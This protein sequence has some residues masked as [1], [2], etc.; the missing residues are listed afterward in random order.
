MSGPRAAD[1]VGLAALVLL[2]LYLGF[3]DRPAPRAPG[4]AAVTPPP[5]TIPNGPRSRT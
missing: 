3:T 1:W 5:E 4:G 2:L